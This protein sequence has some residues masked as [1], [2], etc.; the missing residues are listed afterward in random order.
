LAQAQDGNEA[1]IPSWEL[2]YG[3]REVAPNTPTDLTG[4]PYHWESVSGQG[5]VLGDVKVD[6]Y[7]PG[8]GM[9]ATGKPVKAVRGYKD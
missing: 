7:G 1:G 5:E 3:G 8:V 9:D 6:A 4:R 2:G